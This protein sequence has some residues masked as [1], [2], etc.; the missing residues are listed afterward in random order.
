[1]EVLSKIETKLL[2]KKKKT[3]LRFHQIK[4]IV[5]NTLKMAY[6]TE[7]KNQVTCHIFMKNEGSGQCR[8]EGKYKNIL[9]FSIFILSKSYILNYL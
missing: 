4:T 1:M 2:L 3:K 8:H 9:F 6:K 5:L 7:R